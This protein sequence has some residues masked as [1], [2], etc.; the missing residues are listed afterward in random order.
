VFPSK[1]IHCGGDEVIASGDTQWNKYNADVTN[2]TA[3]GITPNN[4]SNSI[5]QYQN[6]LSTNMANFIQSKGRMMMGWSEFEADGIV[7]NAALMDWETGSSSYAAA[8]ASA[9]CPVV[10]SP[11]STCYIN[12]VEG[13]NTNNLPVEPPFVVGGVPNYLSVSQVYAFNPMPSGLS[14]A[15][16]SNILGAQCNLWG[17][18]VPS[19]RNVMFKMFPRETAMAEITWTPLASQ[20]YSSFT[21]RLV[22]QKQRFANMGVNCDNESVP[23]IGSWGPTVS[24]SPVTNF[25]T[26][27]T[28]VT[29]A[30]EY[31]VSFWRVSGGNLTITSV[32]LLVNGV[33][34]DIDTHTGVA[35]GY[36]SGT[37]PFIPV[38]TLYVLHLPET[39]P[40]AT[41]TI[42]AV[43]Q[44]SSSA[45]S[46]TVY[47][48]NWN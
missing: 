43:T 37:E 19:F 20:N 11:D 18:Y 25:Y 34:V 2:M 16:A 33:Q 48:P 14:S 42:Q 15:Y 38:F 27:T 35:S 40:G 29:T 30:G 24:T 47:L 17:E 45:A 3:H 4:G 5:I 32:A 28:N 13:T 7:P 21:N 23:Q 39:V 6:W 12:Y 46:G 41:Y 8:A 26:I 9:G 22:A 1:Y 31:D 44:S 10:M 36:Q